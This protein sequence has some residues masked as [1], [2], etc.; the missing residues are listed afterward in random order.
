[1][2]A[3]SPSAQAYAEGAVTRTLES[4]DNKKRPPL[5]PGMVVTDVDNGD[6]LAVVGSRH[7]PQ[8]GFHRA[9][10]D[11]RP[12][13]SLLKPFVYILELA[14]PTKLSLQYEAQ[15]GG[16]KSGNTGRT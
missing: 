1:M 11:K 16:D 12:V 14:S 5:Q 10:E 15:S 2:T 7:F 8:H 13:G 4:L 6:V 3:M 9:T